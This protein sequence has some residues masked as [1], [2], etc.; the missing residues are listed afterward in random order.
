M[1]GCMCVIDGAAVVLQRDR[2]GEREK[3]GQITVAVN[4][5]WWALRKGDRGYFRAVQRTEEE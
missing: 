1:R 2:E 4:A 3:L 5:E